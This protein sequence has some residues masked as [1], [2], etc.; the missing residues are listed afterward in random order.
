MPIIPESTRSSLTWKLSTRARE[1]WPQIQQVEVRFHN[2]FAYVDAVLADGDT[3]K[4]C[5]LR[6][7]G[8]ASV[9]GFAIWRASHDDYQD[10]WLATGHPAGPPEEA[11]DTACGLYLDDPTAWT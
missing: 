11:L 4:L 8:Y 7:S 3:A 10:S 9:W 5:R 6:Y 1:R 2:P